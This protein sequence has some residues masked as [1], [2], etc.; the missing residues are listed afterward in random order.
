MSGRI[1]GQKI[2]VTLKDVQYLS[3]RTYFSHRY[4]QGN[5]ELCRKRSDSI[6]DLKKL[7]STLIVPQST[8]KVMPG[9]ILK[10]Y[11]K[12]HISHLCS[13]ALELL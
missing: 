9:E 11:F 13:M 10:Q 12:S 6:H 1:K 7:V 2:D 8:I 3:K 5:M 4:E